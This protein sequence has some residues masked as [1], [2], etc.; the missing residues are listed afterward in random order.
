MLLDEPF[1][2]LDKNLRLDMQIEF[3]RIQRKFDL[4][5]IVTHDQ[6]EAFV[7]HRVIVPAG[8]RIERSAL[9]QPSM[10]DRRPFS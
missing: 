3:L 6:E 10:I 2:A 7:S 5:I 8:G 1:G 9:R 4:S